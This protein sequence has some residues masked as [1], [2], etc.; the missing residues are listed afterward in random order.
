M[1][2]TY[3]RDSEMANAMVVTGAL[4]ALLGS[5]VASGSGP[6]ERVENPSQDGR[7]ANQLDVELEFM[8]SPYR[9]TVDRVDRAKRGRRS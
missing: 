8:G 4:W 9:L 7:L 1:S 5:Q 6:L 3:D 2:D